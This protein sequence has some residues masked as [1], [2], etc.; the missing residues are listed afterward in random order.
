MPKGKKGQ[1]PY[2]RIRELGQDRV[3]IINRKLLSGQSTNVIAA[4]M[5]KEWG[6]D[7]PSVSAGGL[8]KQLVR[9]RKDVLGSDMVGLHDG[10]GEAPK[11]QVTQALMSLMGIKENV[12]GLAVMN[13][14][15]QVERLRIFKVLEKED[16]MNLQFDWLRR[17]CRDLFAMIRD[18]YDLQFE[19][20]LIARVPKVTRHNVM[21]VFSHSTELGERVQADEQ[22]HIQVTE[23]TA[24]VI[25]LLGAD[26]DES[27]GE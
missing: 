1:P 26:I 5:L 9:Y 25:A 17:E 27:N 15:I 21:G 3:D 24:K 12:N 14:M 13:E 6:K 8:A 11:K 10:P 20:G 18:Y 2:T 19:M 16:Q 22:A 4:Y 23:A 7:L